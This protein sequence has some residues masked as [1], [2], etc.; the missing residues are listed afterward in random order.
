MFKVRKH[1]N[2]NVDGPS[3]SKITDTNVETFIEGDSKTVDHML[4]GKLVQKAELRKTLNF[5]P[6]RKF[7]SLVM[8]NGS[9]IVTRPCENV[10]TH[11]GDLQGTTDNSHIDIDMD[12]QKRLQIGIDGATQLTPMDLTESDD[13]IDDT[14]Q[15]PGNI[16]G[17]S[18]IGES[19]S[20]TPEGPAFNRHTPDNVIRSDDGLPDLATPMKRKRRTPGC[21]STSRTQATIKVHQK[22]S[23]EKQITLLDLFI[24]KK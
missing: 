24:R 12:L 13:E 5:T 23:N 2:F 10:K 3:T 4:A 1:L 17:D 19:P 8:K 11:I 18:R 15:S 22:E 9:D 6:D 20:R 14:A 21:R 7:A 16:S